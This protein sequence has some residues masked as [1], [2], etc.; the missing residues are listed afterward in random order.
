MNTNPDVAGHRAATRPRPVGEGGRSASFS[1]EEG[2]LDV[3][4]PGLF[5]P[6]REE[7]CRRLADAA[8]GQEGVRSVRVCL[9]SGSCRVE[10]KAGRVGPSEMAGRFEEAVRTAIARDQVAGSPD[11]RQPDW[12]SLMVFSPEEG[13]ST[14]ETTREGQ[15]SLRLRHRALLDK[16]GLARQVARGLADVPGIDLS[17]A[18]IWGRDLEVRFDPERVTPVAVLLAAEGAYRRAIRPAS[19][20]REGLEEST[21]A[22][23]TGPR[24]LWYLALAGGSFGLTVVGLVVPGIPTVPFLLA[25]SYYLA[26]S[27]PALNRR[28]LRSKFFGPILADLERDGGLRR[29]NKIKLIGFTLAVGV[30]TLVLVGPS[31]PILLVMA[32]GISASLYAIT[33]IRDIPAGPDPVHR[34]GLESAIA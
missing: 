24:R 33:R 7:F 16:R 22:V 20:R 2:F 11:H 15:G 21:P 30:V 9:T 1:E 27:S 14:W 18:T 19:E 3:R 4:D 12:T 32:A 23:V 28:L 26:R 34:P 8:A 31:L 6:G 29:I 17:R 10:F 13:G 5:R 25:T